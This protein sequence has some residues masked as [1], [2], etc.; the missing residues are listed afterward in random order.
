MRVDVGSVEPEDTRAVEVTEVD[1]EM[2]CSLKPAMAAGRREA[3]I[4]EVGTELRKSRE[5]GGR[6]L[7]ARELLGWV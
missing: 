3:V 6:A 1:W 4:L 5:Q 2:S 7:V